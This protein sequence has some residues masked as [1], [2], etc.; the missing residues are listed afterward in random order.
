MQCAADPPLTLESFRKI[1]EES[2]QPIKDD[3]TEMRA[4]LSK[5]KQRVDGM[6]RHVGSLL[7]HQARTEAERLFSGG[8][9]KPLLAQ[10]LQDLAILLPDEAV[11][12]NPSSKEVCYSTRLRDA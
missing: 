10:S 3:L 1:M 11:H 12:N 9:A 5:V 8:Y 7:E 4:D 2:L 6:D